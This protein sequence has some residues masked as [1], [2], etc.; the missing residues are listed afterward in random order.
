MNSEASKKSRGFSGYFRSVPFKVLYGLSL[1]VSCL[2]LLWVGTHF[3]TFQ[4]DGCFIGVE[5]LLAVLLI[6]EFLLRGWKLGY[7]GV[8]SSYF[9]LSDVAAVSVCLAIVLV[10]FVLQT[11]GSGLEAEFCCVVLCIRNLLLFLRSVLICRDSVYSPSRLDSAESLQPWTALE[12]PLAVPPL[13]VPETD[14]L[15]VEEFSPRGRYISIS[16]ENDVPHRMELVEDGTGYELE[17]VSP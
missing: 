8:V 15:D 10:A 3:P 12:Q 16:E 13:E 5:S 4:S 17:L 7:R 9:I 11:A 1:A 6:L 14:V 2:S